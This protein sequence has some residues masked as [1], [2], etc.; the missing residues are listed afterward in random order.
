MLGPLEFTSTLCISIMTNIASCPLPWC[1][2]PLCGL[3][4][5]DQQLLLSI[6]RLTQMQLTLQQ[7]ASCAGLRAVPPGILS[8]MP[9]QAVVALLLQGRNVLR[10]E[11]MSKEVE[12]EDVFIFN[13]GFQS[14]FYKV[15]IGTVSAQK[16]SEPE[17]QE[18]RLKVH[19]SVWQNSSICTAQHAAPLHL[20]SCALCRA[21]YMHMQATD[22][23][24][25]VCL[26]I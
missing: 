21:L 19:L 15:K 6:P 5:Q 26:H 16:E 17:K 25:L 3:L 20:L 8:M 24:S 9:A 12:D 11:P 10:K 23:I 22:M 4:H 18:T 13:E 7:T 14:K 1:M 2:S